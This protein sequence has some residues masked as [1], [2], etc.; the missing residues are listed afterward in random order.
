[1]STLTFLFTD[2]EGSTKLWEKDPEDMR[3]ALERHDAIVGQAI[4]GHGGDVFKTVGDAFYASF[5]RATDAV[6]AAASL[7]RALTAEDWATLQ[8][9]AGVEPLR[10]RVAL[11]AGEVYTRDGDYFGPTLNR[12]AR[13]LAT[14]HGGQVLISGSVAGLV[15]ASLAAVEPGATLLD[16]GEHRL[17]DL[18]RAEHVYQLVLPDLA[19]DFPRI[20]S[21]DTH[22]N[23]L[24]SVASSFVGREQELEELAGLLARHRLVTVTGVGGAGKTR[25]ALQAAA[26]VLPA[27][28]DG[29]WFVDLAPLSEPSLVTEAVAA[30][31]TPSEASG[32]E[33]L[34][35][36]HGPADADPA[37]TVIARRLR[38]KRMLLVLDNCE[39][40]LDAAANLVDAVL[41]H[42]PSVSV[43]A[44]SREP[45]RLHGESVWP[46]KPLACPD[47]DRYRSAD[48]EA[49]AS[50]SGYEAVRLFLDRAASVQAGFAVSEANAAQI[51]EI[52]HRL[53]GIPLAIELAAARVRLLSPAQLAQRLDDRFRLLT[54]GSRTAL[55]RQQTLQALI[56]WS[57]DLLAPAE[58]RVLERL[59]VFAGPGPIDAAV[60]VGTGD[61]VDEPTAFDAVASLVEKSLLVAEDR[62]EARWLR[63]LETIRAYAGKHLASTGDGDPARVRLLSWYLDYTAPEWDWRASAQGA[64]WAHGLLPHYQNL[65]TIVLWAAER[66]AEAPRAIALAARLWYVWAPPREALTVLEA[67]RQAVEPDTPRW[68]AGMI[69]Y[70]LALNL[71]ALGRYDDSLRCFDEAHTAL[72]DAG[73]RIR[74]A[75][76]VQDMGTPLI[77]Q[78]NLEAAAAQCEAAVALKRAAGATPADVAIALNNLARVHWQRRDLATASSLFLEALEMI[79]A[80]DYAPLAELPLFNLGTLQLER[81]NPGEAR[82]LLAEAFRV[83]LAPGLRA[84]CLAGLARVAAAGGDGPKAAR[85]LSG[86]RRMFDENE[87]VLDIADQADWDQ[88]EATVKALLDAHEWE[89]AWA[90]GWA[91]SQDELLVHARETEVVQA[92]G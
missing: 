70:A 17:K 39:H 25:L 7:Q 78:G 9:T 38:Q 12:V 26:N 59:S 14:G 15:G 48:A 74:E 86:G 85:L 28:P 29:A 45:L 1:M 84:M 20:R 60:A 76:V 35:L 67:L 19:S 33:A 83:S 81:G 92:S 23:N 79:P 40:V 36:G 46:I 82:Q 65:R 16:L 55:P 77:M 51:A 32:V 63:L 57:F 31:L 27:F 44:T 47:P 2:I 3:L 43:L 75:W 41:R 58:Q 30:V 61:D 64:A 49:L 24:P 10:V 8:P 13:L 80:K 89:C 56:D 87:I 72:V 11:H 18:G 21:L 4:T 69:A 90:E 68:D 50:L 22:P 73:D 5:G 6:L 66:K 62:G 71:S 54:G 88:A 53:D 52:C 34:L 37:G 42:A 91:M